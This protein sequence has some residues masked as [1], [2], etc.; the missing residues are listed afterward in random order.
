ML[1]SRRCRTDERHLGMAIGRDY[2]DVSPIRGAYR[3]PGAK[4]IMRVELNIGRAVS[5]TTDG[6]FSSG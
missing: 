3:S 1:A 5:I 4:S 2:G 6:N